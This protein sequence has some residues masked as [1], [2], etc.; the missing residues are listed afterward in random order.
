MASPKC[1][2]KMAKQTRSELIP[3]R[4]ISLASDSG[5]R[6]LDESHVTSLMAVVTN[7]DWGAT[8]LAGPSLIA[9]GGKIITS[10][11]DG[12]CVIFNGKHMITALKRFGD[13]IEGLTEAQLES[14]EWW[15]DVVARIFQHGLS[16]TVFEFQDGVYSHLRHRSV[17]ALAHEED[18]NKLLHTTML[19]K[20]RL[21]RSYFEEE[22][23]DWSKA[24]KSILEA[25]GQHKRRTISRWLI[26]ARDCSE[27]A[28]N[29][30]TEIGLKELPMKY[31][32]ENK[33]LVGKV[34]DARY[35][36]TD[37][38]AK[39]ALTWL[40][41]VLVTS[42]G[43]K[44][45]I[46][47]EAFVQ[48]FCVPAKHAESWLKA[49]VKIFG[50]VATSFRAFHRVAERLRQPTGRQLILKWL[51]DP[52][53]RSKPNFAIEE[54]DL[55][56][57]EMTNTKAGT[58]KSEG[59]QAG[60]SSHVGEPPSDNPPYGL[61]MD[62]APPADEDDDVGCLLDVE[63][64]AP[65]VD[66]VMEKADQLAVADMASISTHTEQTAF[67]EELRTAIFPSSR[68][69]VVV[70]CPTSRA[71]VFTNFFDLMMEVPVRFSLLV[72]LGHRDELISTVRPVLRR[73]LPG[74]VIY[75]VALSVG[76]QSERQ[77][78]S[79]VLFVPAT[80]GAVTSHVGLEGCRA[81]SAE[82]VRLRCTSST[83]SMRVA[84][85]GSVAKIGDVG[86]EDEEIP[87][88]D[89]E[90][91]DFESCFDQAE[92]GGSGD[93]AEE[94]DKG[95]QEAGD[96]ATN[97]FAYAA[98]LAVHRKVLSAI[99]AVQTR[100][101]LVVLTRTAHPGLLV[102]GRGFGLKV[103]A[104]MAG[105][106]K[107]SGGHGALLLKKLMMNSKMAVARES[108]P[109]V[110]HGS[111]RVH[112]G[113]FQFQVVQT[114]PVQPVLLHDVTPAVTNWR[115]GFNNNPEG[116]DS[117]AM[118]QV[119]AESDHV[120][121]KMRLARHNGTES[122]VARRSMRDGDVVCT[123]GGLA[124]DS[125]EKLRAFIN[126]NPIGRDFIGSLVRIDGVQHEASID[127]GGQR[128]SQHGGSGPP[129]A[130]I[131]FVTTGIGKYV[132]HYSQVG[133]RQANAVL[134]CNIG[135]GVCDGLLLLMVKTRNKS[136]IAAGSPIILN[137]GMD[138]D[139]GVVERVL[140]EDGSQPKR[141][142]TML[143]AYFRQLGEREA[144]EAAASSGEATELAL[145]AGQATGPPVDP[146]TRPSDPPSDPP[147]ASP[148]PTPVPPVNT[149][150]I[151][152]PILGP[153]PPPE[154]KDGG[155]EAVE[156]KLSPGEAVVGEVSLPFAAK[157]VYKAKSAGAAG[158]LRLTAAVKLPGNKKIPPNTVL[159][160]AKDGTM[161]TAGADSSTARAAGPAA[162][163]AAGSTVA[164]SGL[165]WQFTKT[166]D[167][168][169]AMAGA[170]PKSLHDVIKDTGATAVTKHK[171]WKG[172]VPTTL[173]FAG[174]STA[175]SFVP[176]SAVTV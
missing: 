137:F 172:A 81:S 73:K 135:A 18:Q 74:R 3:L 62:G 22:G 40:G 71:S 111:K 173:E 130:P 168:L 45:N 14:I 142:R 92:A 105:V 150:P 164:P 149:P 143:D 104:F 125:I 8:T 21:V 113:D 141:M 90:D 94:G 95:Q 98:P 96:R 1:T 148:S 47:S 153:K 101:H 86:L 26:L 16:F 33:Y 136:G 79:Y 31:V 59:N 146:S 4:E 48:E 115:T 46:S 147:I 157:L 50:V 109:G 145:V 70:E 83:C 58:N 156:V 88:E 151:P 39:V 112:E 72:P 64:A 35:R 75:T 25:L 13:T 89:R 119:Q 176:T 117:K 9:E 43:G 114:N 65:V 7:K 118:A 19:Q 155:S 110:Q 165:S 107:H 54:L 126:T 23:K 44:Q 52:Q 123:I 66:P 93:E 77:R 87:V 169:V 61:G 5:W 128:E 34:A 175:V 49:Q 140:A 122:I 116:L 57:K 103:I 41:E 106:S 163:P 132:R 15:D 120:G 53:L 76:K 10:R 68:P 38:W 154:P 138:Y 129:A 171:P 63:A 159:A 162:G 29:H 80:E 99:G 127:E 97:L 78:P 102:A 108:L 24:E 82:G 133:L 124:F 60:G 6:E 134:S 166:K 27:A 69:L 36:L 11:E 170:P 139:H 67:I 131:Y 51:Q 84:K 2:S 56:V 100:T 160:V 91:A 121:C 32:V 85:S 30:M 174:S 17:Q 12:K 161:G 37:D 20:A 55:L 144:A 158:S 42:G 28:L 152:A 167:V